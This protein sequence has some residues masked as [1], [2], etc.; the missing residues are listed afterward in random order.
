MIGDRW[1]VTAGEIARSYP[2][3]D[4][5]TSPALQAWRGVHVAAPADAVWPW[6][7]Q[8]RLAPYSYDWIDNL[9]RH[10]PRELVT[11]PEPRV[12]DRFTAVRGRELGRIVSVAPGT[13]LT[14]TIM[15]AFM[16]YVLVPQDHDTTRLLLKAVMQSC[17][18]AAFALSIGDLIMARRQLLNWKNLAERDH[19]RATAQDQWT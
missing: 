9:G 13:Q 15:G 6:V 2:C 17:H 5:V 3:D 10:S 7:A 11:L 4:F 14:G 1:G 19:R 16:S 18:G 12:G 8:V